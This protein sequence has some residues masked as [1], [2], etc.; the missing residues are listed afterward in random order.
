MIGDFDPAVEAL[1]VALLPAV[2][3]LLVV[4]L[5]GVA[6]A[7]ADHDRVRTLAAQPVVELVFQFLVERRSGFVEKHRL[8]SGEQDPG[9]GDALL[10]TRR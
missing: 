5:D 9:E 1:A 6:G 7:H 3:L 2:E 8:G 10:L 4:L